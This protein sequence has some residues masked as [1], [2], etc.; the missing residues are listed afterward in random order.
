MDLIEQLKTT[1]KLQTSEDVKLFVDTL[2]QMAESKRKEYITVMLSYLDDD[3]DLSDIQKNI[4]GMAETFPM[5][6]YVEAVINSINILKNKAQDWLDY[7]HY[8]ITNSEEYTLVYR[9]ALI[10]AKDKTDVVEFLEG[11][12]QNNP[13]KSDKIKLI[14]GSN[15]ERSKEE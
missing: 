4:I 12:S 8:R 14:I 10:D 5:E 6:E 7:I 2:K 3:S 15:N 9:D 11:F 13:E 1:S